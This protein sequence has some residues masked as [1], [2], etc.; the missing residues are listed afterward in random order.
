MSIG[1]ICLLMVIH[2]VIASVALPDPNTPFFVL[3][4]LLFLFIGEG[5]ILIWLI[6][7]RKSTPAFLE[8]VVKHLS[9]AE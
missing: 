5:L 3:V 2:A 7:A 4:I 8:R 9:D 1:M 6:R